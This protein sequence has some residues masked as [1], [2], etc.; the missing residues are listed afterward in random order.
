MAFAG[1][2]AVLLASYVVHVVDSSRCFSVSAS[3]VTFSPTQKKKSTSSI[4]KA[5]R[6][7]TVLWDI[8]LVP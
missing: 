3:P 2:V 1:Q 8:E 6:T 7:H 4:Q 5:M